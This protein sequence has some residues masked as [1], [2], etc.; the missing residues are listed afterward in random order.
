MFEQIFFYSLCAILKSKA[1]ILLFIYFSYSN[2]CC[3][4]RPVEPLSTKLYLIICVCDFILDYNCMT[5]I[6]RYSSFAHALHV[7][8]MMKLFLKKKKKNSCKKLK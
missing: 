5:S 7:F 2:I 6:Y 3:L 8:A 4:L 1:L